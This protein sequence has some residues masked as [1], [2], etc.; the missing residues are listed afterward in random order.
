VD[1]VR[2]NRLGSLSSNDLADAV[3]VCQFIGAAPDQDVPPAE[4]WSQETAD[5]VLGAADRI[6]WYRS[7]G[8]VDRL[9]VDARLWRESMERAR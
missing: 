8:R 4:K 3:L 6:A 1:S 2:L 5:A 9:L 7:V